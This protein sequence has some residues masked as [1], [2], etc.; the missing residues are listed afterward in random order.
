MIRA[1]VIASLA[2]SGLGLAAC[3]PKVK[4]P[5]EAGVCYH[6]IPLSDGTVRFNVLA[7]NQPQIE[8]CAARLEELRI[9]FRRNTQENRDLAGSY[10]GRFIFLDRRGVQ[11][12]QS[13]NG[14]RIFA[15]ART[16][17]GRLAMPGAIRRQ[18]QAEGDPA[19]TRSPENT[20]PPAAA[21]AP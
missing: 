6:A 9:R 2:A 12:A 19:G 16:G 7:R 21:P 3:Q 1:A 15:L 11:F 4:A 10:Q 20:P 5:D 14:A 18:M 13:W 8:Y 17:D